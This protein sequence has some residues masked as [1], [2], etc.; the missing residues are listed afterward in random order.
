[1]DKELTAHATCVSPALR[2]QEDLEPN[3]MRWKFA[4]EDDDAIR[5]VI[6]RR[7]FNSAGHEHARILL[8][9]VIEDWAWNEPS[10]WDRDGEDFEVVVLGPKNMAGAWNVRVFATPCVTAELNHPPTSP[11]P[12][13]TGDEWVMVP[14]AGEGVRDMAEAARHWAQRSRKPGQGID[15]LS[16]WLDAYAAM[17]SAAPSPPGKESGACRLTYRHYRT[18][19]EVARRWKHALDLHREHV[20]HLF[21]EYDKGTISLDQVKHRAM[22]LISPISDQDLRCA[23]DEA[24][25]IAEE[26]N[27]ESQTVG[28]GSNA[29][30]SSPS[31]S[32]AIA[33]ERDEE[34]ELARVIDEAQNEHAR[35]MLDGIPGP[36]DKFIARAVLTHLR[37]QRKASDVREEGGA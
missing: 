33:Q 31:G 12:I 24:V 36:S 25:G 35:A 17:L 11:S 2:A 1:M 13:A 18:P 23:A 28:G 19:D 34:V 5:L 26:L 21:S 37:A 4:H 29:D 27:R 20:E 3:E 8:Q 30:A 10:A 22:M 7:K 14:R 15:L 16:F 6:S 9:E 32:Q